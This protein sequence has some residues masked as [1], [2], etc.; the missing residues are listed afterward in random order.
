MKR[1]TVNYLASGAVVVAVLIFLFM[2]LYNITGRSGDTDSYYAQYANVAGLRYGTPVYFDGYRIGQVEEVSPIHNGARTDFRVDFS[3]EEGWPIPTDSIAE[4]ATAG[5]LSD[6]FILLRQGQS[7]TMLEPESKVI[8]KESSDVFAA[9]NDLAVEIQSL[10]DSEL[11]PLIE[12]VSQRVDSITANFETSTPELV[13]QLESML[14]KLDNAAGSVETI[15]GPENQQMLSNTLAN[16][17]K[18]S[19]SSE[20]L[21]EE[22]RATQKDLEAMLKEARGIVVENRPEVDAM[23]QQMV[24]A[25]ED[26]SIRLESIGFHLDES[27]R[28]F[29]EFTRAIRRSPNRL[30]FTPDD[31]QTAAGEQ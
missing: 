27:S 18:M 4:I 17:E 5:L 1:D 31:D 7:E 19:A 26:A 25:I 23:V 2:V 9:L 14:A 20:Q 12:L 29:N 28:N 13:S 11:K 15:L 8:G 6:V 21:A 24:S 3:V 10:T 16:F 30:L 22:L